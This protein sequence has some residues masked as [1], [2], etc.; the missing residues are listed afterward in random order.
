MK[1]YLSLII[2]FCLFVLT[3]N[4]AFAQSA[5]ELQLGLSRDFGYGGLGNDIQGLF[6]MKIKNPPADMNKVAF[7]I[8]GN[9]IGEDNQAPF[10]YQFNTD[11]YPLGNHTLNAIGYTSSGQEVN[12][13]AIQVEF[14]PAS[15]ATGF[16]VKLIGPIL[17]IIVLMILI[18]VGLP[19]L[20]TRGK[21][22]ALPSG[23]QRNYGFGGGA[24]CPKCGR[25]FPIKLWWIN[26]GLSKIDR[27]PYCGKWSFVRTRSMAELRAAEA[28]ELTRLQPDRAVVGETETDKLHKDLDESKYQDV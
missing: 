19:M 28:A 2:V 16:I 27:C 3:T 6:T 4:I 9:V 26:L 15:T 14:V 20:R 22:S 24:I 25:P 5:G 12:S 18:S 11:S 1:K 7:M 8:D 17:G 13:N 21:L 10:G 23:A